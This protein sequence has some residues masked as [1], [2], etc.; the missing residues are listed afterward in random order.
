MSE[1]RPPFPSLSPTALAGRCP[2]CGERRRIFDSDP[3]EVACPAC[4]GGL[5][6]ESLLE[7]SVETFEP[8]R[9]DRFDLLERVGEGAS[10]EVWKAWD[11]A[12]GRTVALKLARP[13]AAPLGAAERARLTRECVVAARLR[14]PRLVGLLDADL[15]RERPHLVFEF[16]HGP[17]LAARLRHRRP[18]ARVAA[19]W[20][21]TLARAL[22]HLHALGVVHRDIKPGNILLDPAP[23]APGGFWP[24]LADFGLARFEEDPRLT[25]A[26]HDA[27]TPAYM[28]PERL[29]GGGAGDARADLY[30]L[31]VV[32]FELLTGRAP[33]V[34]GGPELAA[35]LLR[36][37]APSPRVYAAGLS[38]DLCA[39]VGRCLEQEPARR[40]ATAAELALELERWGEGRPVRARPPGPLGRAA[41]WA[42]RQPL[43]A[44]LAAALL[45]ATAGLGGF[46]VAQWRRALRAAERAESGR[47]LAERLAREAEAA[48]EEARAERD[49]AAENLRRWAQAELNAAAAERRLFDLDAGP[50][51]S[52]AA[53]DEADRREE[54]ALWAA[55]AVLD[56][57]LPVA[58]GD[59]AAAA[60]LRA[61]DRLHDEIPPGELISAGRLLVLAEIQA[62]RALI[63]R[64]LGEG[65]KA[66]F[67]AGAA[68]EILE[69]ARTADIGAFGPGASAQP[70]RIRRV[71]A[72]VA[73]AAADAER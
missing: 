66:R 48:A 65:G 17:S 58:E 9:R 22:D 8:A 28:A 27:G 20:V 50:G 59:A 21:A 42:V 55:S 73:R 16:V 36:G 70:E 62:N 13:G 63:A 68:A 31:G 53:Q 34:G 18:D 25:A 35:A 33:H 44:T 30:A 2:G 60:R 54:S 19:A 46:G 71:E 72:R 23:E 1:P 26:S 67:L 3:E 15:E 11:G 47:V 14:H 49:Q 43:A 64:A 41:R 61:L 7:P 10:A 51:R 45:L 38:R 69:R 52:R 29:V 32:L 57:S 37:P 5:R 6:G 24:R 40:Y 39:V 4:G 12:V 56:A